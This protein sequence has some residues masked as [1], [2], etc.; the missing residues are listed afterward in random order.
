[1][2]LWLWLV[3]VALLCIIDTWGTSKIIHEKA[4]T[5]TYDLE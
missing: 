3:T 5:L 4:Y 1:M 2:F